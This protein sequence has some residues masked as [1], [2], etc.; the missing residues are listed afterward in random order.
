MPE[1]MHSQELHGRVPRAVDDLHAA[2]ADRPDRRHHAGG[3]RDEE[4]YRDGRLHEP[5][6]RARL[7]RLRRGDRRRQEPS[8]SGAD[9][10]VHDHSGHAAAGDRHGSGFGDM[11]ADG[12]CRDRRSDVLDHSHAVHRSGAL[13]DPREPFAAQGA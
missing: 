13:L 8:A 1:H 12:H 10:L 2:V 11:A 4:R 7:G 6:D 3:H 5:P 9:D